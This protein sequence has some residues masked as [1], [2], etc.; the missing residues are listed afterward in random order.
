MMQNKFYAICMSS[1]EF[2]NDNCFCIVGRN[3]FQDK[4]KAEKLAA[5]C[6]DCEMEAGIKYYVLEMEVV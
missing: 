2:E 3:I 1:D 4:Q 6:Q 5:E